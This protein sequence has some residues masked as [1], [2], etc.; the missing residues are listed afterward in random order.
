MITWLDNPLHYSYVRKTRYITISP[1]FPVKSLG[2]I[3]PE[4]G[5]LIGY[6]MVERKNSNTEGVYLYHHEFY[7]LKKHDR[8]LAP[9][10]VYQGPRG[11]CGRMPVEAV[12]PVG[13]VEGIH[14]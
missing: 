13:L 3:F 11:F 2:K 8:D 7:W 1:R 5:R 12:D 10:G 14:N 9:D 6:T 4:L